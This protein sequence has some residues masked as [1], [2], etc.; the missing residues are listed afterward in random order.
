MAQLPGDPDYEKGQGVTLGDQT[1]TWSDFQKFQQNQQAQGNKLSWGDYLR[2]PVYQTSTGFTADKSEVQPLAKVSLNKDT[3]AIDISASSDFLGSDV[4]KNNYKP[5]LEGLSQTYRQNPDAT[6]ALDKEGDEWN[7]ASKTVEEWIE[8]LN[9]ENGKQGIAQVDKSV[10]RTYQEIRDS[11][12]SMGLTDADIKAGKGWT[13]N[14]IIRKYQTVYETGDIKHYGSDLQA[15]PQTDEWKEYLWNLFSKAGING[16][17]GES[18]T[19]TKE[20]WEQWYNRKNTSRD[21][22][23]DLYTKLRQEYHDAVDARD[24]ARI[25]N[26]SALLSTIELSDPEVGNFRKVMDWT[27]GFWVGALNSASD[28]SSSFYNLFYS[29]PKESTKFVGGLL[30]QDESFEDEVDAVFSKFTDIDNDMQDIA[31]LQGE[32]SKALGSQIAAGQTVGG[33]AG[34]IGKLAFAVWAGNRLSDAFGTI[35][36]GA[37]G[38]AIK[39][40]NSSDKAGKFVRGLFNGIDTM[41][42]LQKTSDFVTVANDAV[43]MVSRRSS[44]QLVFSAITKASEWIGETIAECVVSDPKLTYRF[45][46]NSDDAEAR[47]YVI[48]NMAWNVGG[49]TA[50]R[51]GGKLVSGLS[52]TATGKFLNRYWTKA[53]MGVRTKMADMADF[54]RA[55]LP[56]RS[57]AEKLQRAEAELAQAGSNASVKLHNRVDRLKLKAETEEANRELRQAAKKVASAKG[58]EA[59]DEAKLVYMEIQNAVDI[60]KAAQARYFAEIRNNPTLSKELNAVDESVAEITKAL[61]KE[62]ATITVYAQAGELGLKSSLAYMDQ[63]TA[64]YVSAVINNM[65]LNNYKELYGSTSRLVRQQKANNEFIKE[66]LNNASEELK[67]AADTATT[68]IQNFWSK[69]NDWATTQGIYNKAEIQALRNSG[70]WGEGGSQYAKLQR[71]TEPYV[72]YSQTQVFKSRDIMGELQRSVMG[73]TE[74]YKDPILTI[75]N[76]LIGDAYDYALKNYSDTLKQIPGIFKAENRLADA[77]Q[78]EFAR[79]IKSSGRQAVKEV[80]N[81]VDTVIS[82][83]SF[84]YESEFGRRA[85]AE[86]KKVVDLPELRQEA[87]QSASRLASIE[88][89]SAADISKLRTNATQRKSVVTSL[90]NEQLAE[91][92][93]EDQRIILS[94]G[95]SLLSAQNALSSISARTVAELDDVIDNLGYMG[96]SSTIEAVQENAENFGAWMSTLS[97][98]GQKEVRNA[99]R[100]ANNMSSKAHVTADDFIKAVESSS[101]YTDDAGQSVAHAIDSIVLNDVYPSSYRAYSN[102]VNELADTDEIRKIASERVHQSQLAQAETTSK[103]SQKRYN[104]ALVELRKEY[105]G[106]ETYESIDKMIDDLIDEAWSRP[107]VQEAFTAANSGLMEGAD[108]G[109]NLVLTELGRSQN[110]KAFKKQVAEAFKKETKSTFREAL[111]KEKTASQI[112]SL[113]NKAANAY[114]DMAEERLLSRAADARSALQEAGSQFSNSKDLFDEARTLAKELEGLTGEVRK[115]I[116]SNVVRILNENG[117]AEFYEVSP[118]MASFF[119]SRRIGH[120]DTGRDRFLRALSSIFRSGTTGPLSVKSFMNQWV[121]DSG[122][123]WVAGNAFR[124]IQ[125]AEEVIAETFGDNVARAFREWSPD[126]LRILGL[127][128]IEDAQELA[129]RELARGAALSPTTTEYGQYQFTR[130]QRAQQLANAGFKGLDELNDVKKWTQTAQGWFDK[131]LEKIDL[132]Q[133]RESYLRNRVYANAYAD[134]IKNGYSIKNARTVA[135]FM[136][137]NA[138][139]N[140]GRSLTHLENLRSTVPYIGAAINGTKSFFRVAELDPVGVMSRI[141]GGFVVPVVALT[142]QNLGSEENRKIYENIPEWQRASSF[143]FVINRQVLTLPLPE[144][145]ADIVAPWR[146]FVEYL[147][148]AQRGTF[149]ELMLNDL[150]GFSPVDFTGFTS[151]DADQIYT[152]P[153]DYWKN[154]ITL[155]SARLLSQFSDPLMKSAI[156]WA[157]GVDPYT[158]NYVD[159]TFYTQDDDGNVIAVDYNSGWLAKKISEIMNGVTGSESTMSAA[160]AQKI[161]QTLLGNANVEV[162]DGLS[163]MAGAIGNL[164]NTGDF[165]S[166]LGEIGDGPVSSLIQEATSPFYTEV[167]DRALTDWRHAVAGLQREKEAILG[168]KKFQTILQKLSTESDPDK[169]ANLKAQKQNYIDDFQMKV[170]NVATQLKDKYPSAV[171]DKYKFSSVLNLMNMNANARGTNVY[172]ETAM[173]QSL[174]KDQKKQ[175]Q[176]QAYNTMLQMGFPDIEGRELTGYITNNF[177]TREVVYANPLSILAYST[178]KQMQKDIHLANIEALISEKDWYSKRQAV[179]QQINAIYNK[180]K[181]KNSDYN[182]IDAIRVAYNSELMKDLAPY[183]NTYTPEMVLGSQDVMNVLSQWIQAPTGT[184]GY[185]KNKTDIKGSAQDAYI[186]N[187]IKAIFKVNDSTYVGGKDYSGRGQWWKGQ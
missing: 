45:L 187:Y 169:I 105:I 17:D 36:S 131:T 30:G 76:N 18:G 54:L 174:T 117:A 136:M 184:L 13:E 106:A 129:S 11:N 177:G 72:P 181:L 92:A 37:L 26:A 103:A 163:E 86:L 153:E 125:N 33:I 50:A 170:L 175:G 73:S 115:G 31:T 27:N 66:F 68:R 40:V 67:L 167:Y 108:A 55:K 28:W 81:S 140:F 91:F 52:N 47:Q 172:A 126:D 70:L 38:K 74:H 23:W 49:W 29:L 128:N 21:D 88:N 32:V 16:Y 57:T 111:K 173:A 85:Q 152:Q 75:Y 64:D 146:Q 164:V 157:T 185:T 77:D 180:G 123:A 93:N 150:V 71:V 132:G 151:V 7:G 53:S 51:A 120:I 3:G 41:L 80:S 78:T 141:L 161:M 56:G 155:G 133:Y 15:L 61:Q 95:S 148:G 90:S 102:T 130:L 186:E 39:A 12:D 135:E 114:A 42:N 82:K 145:V 58:Q 122:N 183:I 182:Q 165:A 83:N 25:A 84:D 112:D 110:T 109:R 100:K 176:M 160:M 116:N 143:C 35:A 24:P 59:F 44:A 149:A 171:F 107:G 94:T 6:F 159:Q 10:Q 62:G 99:I 89:R 87:T 1:F 60:F 134:A 178:T 69:Y 121:K 19:I 156:I 104:D 43:N 79:K 124:S 138:T 166:F 142:A 119:N 8:T 168:D 34:E 96:V 98:N 14:D 158:G 97:D 179:K 127:D 48:E 154:K 137:N 5:L 139:T 46:A 4:Y 65:K 20:G 144:Q 113:V 9:D 2:V 22:I 118:A 63:K 101:A 162:I 147:Y